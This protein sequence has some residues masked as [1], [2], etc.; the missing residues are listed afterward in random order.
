MEHCSPS[1]EILL[2]WI[3][4]TF[5][6]PLISIPILFLR[7]WITFANIC[8]FHCNTFSPWGHHP[9]LVLRSLNYVCKH[10]AGSID[11]AKLGGI[12]CVISISPFMDN[13]LLLTFAVTTRMTINTLYLPIA[14][15]YLS[16]RVLS[17]VLCNQDLYTL[18]HWFTNLFTVWERC[19]LTL[20][21]VYSSRVV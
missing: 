13:T 2:A 12:G 9:C 16:L 20:L 11:F 7:R 3:E 4:Q 17:R 21:A 15:G 5:S 6:T 1:N 10:I 14:N 18:Y 8:N 19:H